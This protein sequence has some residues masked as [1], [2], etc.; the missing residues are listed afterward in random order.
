[1][2]ITLG[3]LAT[4]M[5]TNA[6]ITE[7]MKAQRQPIKRL[8]N[9]RNFQKTRLTAFT[10]FDKKLKDLLSKAEAMETSPKFLV[11]KVTQSSQ[12]FFTAT[13][14]SNATK[15]A[16]NVEVVSLARQ[17]KEVAAGVADG[18]TS[19]GGDLIINGKTVSIAVGSTLEQIR[20]AIN[21]TA[22][23][24]A[25]ASIINDGSVNLDG[26]T[27]PFRLVFTAS[28]AGVNGV[29]ITGNTTELNFTPQAGS[30]AQVKVD[31][32]N[33]FRTSNTIN[34]AVAGVTFDLVKANKDGETSSLK[35]DT[36]QSAVRQK[37]TDF[38]K[39]Y[40]DIVNF[41]NAQKDA[42]WGRDSGLQSP[43]S[44]LQSLLTTAVGGSNSL[45]TLSGL[46]FATQ[47]DGTLKTDDTKLS[48]A[49]KDNLTGVTTLLTGGGG[50]EG[51]TT[52]FKNYLLGITNSVDGLLSSRQK[53]T[54]AAVKRINDSIERMETRLE[55]RE[56]TMR[57]QFNALESLVGGMNSQSAFLTQQINVWN[58]D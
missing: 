1:M 31:G 51:I 21:T 11:N 33:I 56:K 54:D 32:V 44:R 10:E 41:V 52:K 26:T 45:Q 42:S 47:K 7:L 18:F 25:S 24:G 16:Y 35:V 40:N 9:D 48:N 30:L 29:D 50:V 2:A 55:K 53:S 17:E 4:G 6:L 5:D 22:D 28:Q 14:S 3:G 58:K 13:A 8:E 23:I 34:D 37:I 46:G 39:S 49:L 57:A 43:K 19:A 27:T 38:V 12:E 20:D 15:G 36:D